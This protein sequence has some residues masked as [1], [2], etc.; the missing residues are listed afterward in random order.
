MH[1]VALNHSA[2]ASPYSALG[3]SWKQVPSSVVM[4]EATEECKTGDLWHLLHAKNLMLTSVIKNV[5]KVMLRNW[6]PKVEKRG[7]NVNIG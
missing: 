7:M 5:M 3:V 6:K 2:T 4:E 1:S